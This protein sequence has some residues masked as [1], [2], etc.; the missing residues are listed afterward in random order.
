MKNAWRSTRR[1]LP[2]VL[3]SLAILVVLALTIDWGSLVLAFSRLDLRF[4]PLHA[5]FYFLSV[6]A[7]ALASRSLLEDRPTFG[8][9]FAAVMQGYLLNNLLP[10]RLGEVGRAYLL[11]RRTGT[12]LFGTLPAILIERAYDLA[13]AAVLVIVTLPF[14][15]SGAE[16]ARP[17]AVWTLALVT[18]G[19]LS[20]H[21]IA[22]FRS[23]IGGWL[24]RLSGRF[25][26]IGQQLLPQAEKALSGLAVLTRLDRFLL[27]L[28]YMSLSWMSIV[29][30]QFA[31]L[32]GFLPGAPWLY[33]TF[34]LGVSSFSGA[35][36]SAP[37][38]LGVFEGTVVV[39]LGIF[40]VSSALALA[41]AVTHHVAHLLYS[42]LIGVWA[43]SRDGESLFGLFARLS[44]KE[45]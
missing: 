35:I 16:W 3:V 31:L 1:W 21:F 2:G 32:R 7:R 42:G 13:F 27:S 24:A 38:G 14:V 6:S 12:G 18:I 40:G 29:L 25:P 23:P 26:S 36:P 34:T 9:S 17:A 39:A 44:K 5:L 30:C 37:A 8:Q 28:V 43:F 19:L 4:L 10:L 15:L 22:R 33:S 11:G 41:Y 45:K 20:L